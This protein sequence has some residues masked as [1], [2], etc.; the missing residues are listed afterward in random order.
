[1]HL[2]R[3]KLLFIVSPGGC[4]NY[5]LRRVHFFGKY[6]INLRNLH[7]PELEAEPALYEQPTRETSSSYEGPYPKWLD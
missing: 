6:D 3:L 7:R 4:L 1:M 5:E 2:R